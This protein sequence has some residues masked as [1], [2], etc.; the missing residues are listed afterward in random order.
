M[1]KMSIQCSLKDSVIRH[2]NF[3][4]SCTKR[5]GLHSRVSKHNEGPCYYSIIPVGGPQ[6]VPSHPPDGCP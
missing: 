6:K 3:R 4:R 1:I 5:G 2:I